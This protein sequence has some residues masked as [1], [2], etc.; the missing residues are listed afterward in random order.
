MADDHANAKRLADGLA[1]IDG[2]SVDANSIQTNI[3]IFDVD[4]KVATAQ[5]LI[6][7]LDREGV[8]VTYPG[9]QSI[10]MVTHRH[11]DSAD[12]DEALGRVSNVVKGLK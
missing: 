5:E 11:I 8:K 6:G 2:L 12:V 1:N 7:A 10:R 9:Q 3:V 4:S